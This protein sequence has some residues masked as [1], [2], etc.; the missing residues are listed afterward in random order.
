MKIFPDTKVYVAC[1]GNIP[2]GGP[3]LLHQFCSLLIQYGIEVYICYIP[4]QN[5][6]PENP[7]E[8]NYRKYCVPYVT[9][10]HEDNPH[11]VLIMFETVGELYFSLNRIQKVFWWLSVDNY[12]SNISILVTRHKENALANPLPKL[13]YFQDTEKDTEHW[14]QSEYARQFVMLNG[15]HEKNIHVVEDYLS[16]TFLRKAARIDLTQKEDAV[17]F[18][19]RK[20]LH[21]TQRLIKLAP[22]IKWFPIQN[23]T[24]EQVQFVLSKAKVYIDF[25]NFPGKDRIPREAA[26]SG[27]VVITGK[28]GAAGNDIDI[29]IPAEFKFDE[30]EEALKKAIEKI[31]YAF[32]NFDEEYSKQKAFR[33]RIL[34]D[35]RRFENEV[36][37]ACNLKSTEK[38]NAAALWQ[39]Y[40]VKS[41]HLL[42]VL[43]G[44]NFGIIPKFIVDDR[45]SNG[46]NETGEF[47]T[48]KNNRNHFNIPD[49]NIDGGYGL[50]FIST[51]DAKFLYVEGRIKKFV[52]LMPDESEFKSLVE[53]ISPE[54]K[55]IVVIGANQK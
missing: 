15:V 41:Y 3:E 1:P 7:V 25:G 22:D 52:L 37:E 8:D 11:D 43:S 9:N 14:V 30:T 49:A 48:R 18:N 51:D 31:R 5:F 27:C 55:D 4:F 39:G 23:M 46:Q 53:K 19:P 6:N 44:Q 47:L 38:I 42:R 40:N 32:E 12:I 26:I 33:E 35:K 21:I 17:L 29:N 20:G 28:R 10:I 13:F 2:T 36:E 34:D 50:P 24:P 16:Q 45:L 54:I